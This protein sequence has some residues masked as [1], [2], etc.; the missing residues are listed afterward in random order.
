MH[1]EIWF[2]MK[3]AEQRDGETLQPRRPTAKQDLLS[4]DSRTIG[5]DERAFDAERAHSGSRCDANKF[6]SGRWKK[7]QSVFKP[8]AHPRGPRLYFQDNL[9]RR[10]RRYAESKIRN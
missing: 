2:V 10:I 4:N 7:R 8:L 9:N 1:R 5:F 3:V 6:S